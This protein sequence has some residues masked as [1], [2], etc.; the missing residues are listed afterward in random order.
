ME[1]RLTFLRWETSRARAW[2]ADDERAYCRVCEQA[3]TAEQWVRGEP[4]PGRPT[5]GS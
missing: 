1:H 3:V 2:A 4:C 5:D